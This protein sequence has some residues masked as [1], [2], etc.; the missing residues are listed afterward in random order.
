MMLNGV[1]SE[2]QVA[3]VIGPAMD[4]G[5]AMPSTAPGRI[6]AAPALSAWSGQ[7]AHGRNHRG[8]LVGCRLFA[9]H[10]A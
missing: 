2:T 1:A 5:Q 7:R 10:Q 9:G 6:S 8:V 3:L 4:L